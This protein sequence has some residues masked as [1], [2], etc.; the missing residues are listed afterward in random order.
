MS[1]GVWVNQA[2]FENA[3]RNIQVPSWQDFLDRTQLQRSSRNV[4]ETDPATA[5][6]SPLVWV[7]VILIN[8]ACMM[9]TGS[10]GSI[11]PI[12]GIVFTILY[13]IALARV[14]TAY[15]EKDPAL[16]F[17]AK[18]LWTVVPL[19]VS[20]CG[21]YVLQCLEMYAKLSINTRWYVLIGIFLVGLPH[22]FTAIYILRRWRH[23][24]LVINII[25][26]TYGYDKKQIYKK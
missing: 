11:S 4:I 6:A 24:P 13:V 23:G 3:L 21:V 1:D 5:G 20:T 26:A 25:G 19:G 8:I 12:C 7:G 15:L 16:K 17:I 10:I 9:F 14:L 18:L 22:F 2:V